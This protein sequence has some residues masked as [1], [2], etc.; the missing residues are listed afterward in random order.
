MS[1][2]LVSFERCGAARYISHLDT[3]R[4][5]QRMFARAGIGLALSQGMRPK[6]RLSLPLP[7]PTGAAGLEELAVVGV[8][9][10]APP[11]ELPARLRALRAASPE[12]VA[13]RGIVQTEERPRPRAAAAAYECRLPAPRADVDDAL[14]WFDAAPRVTVER[15]S[16]KGHRAVEVKEYVCGLSASPA[17]DQTTLA[18]TLRYRA[19]GSARVDEVVAALAGR[20][21]IEPVVLD[22]VRTHVDWEGLPPGKVLGTATGLPGRAEA[23][24]EQG[25]PCGHEPGTGQLSPGG[26]AAGKGDDTQ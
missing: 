16:P 14:R 17:G 8:L 4:V 21:G 24:P 6:P 20:L 5:V 25:L 2:W 11:D 23:G 7:L 1:W 26:A 10:T 19:D 3:T 18:F 9:E 13:V 22:L 15:T 12:G